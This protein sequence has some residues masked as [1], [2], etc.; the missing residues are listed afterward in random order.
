MRLIRFI[1]IDLALML[2]APENAESMTMATGANFKSATKAGGSLMRISG[3]EPVFSAGVSR[4]LY[5]QTSQ[6]APFGHSAEALGS[7]KQDENLALLERRF[8]SHWQAHR[9]ACDCH[10]ARDAEMLNKP[11][12][13]TPICS[14]PPHLMPSREQ[15]RGARA[16]QTGLSEAWRSSPLQQLCS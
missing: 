13:L 2:L 4:H 10:D 15:R 6:A 3:S 9:A 7:A 11:L 1:L 14:P 5:R 16:A 12:V 8:A